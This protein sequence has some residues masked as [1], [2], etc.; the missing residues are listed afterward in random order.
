MNM[1]VS[2]IF[3]NVG[4]A[5]VIAMFLLIGSMIFLNVA[6]MH[7]RE[8]VVPDFTNMSVADAQVLASESD[9]RVEVIDSLYV[10]RMAKGHIY[11]QNPKSGSRV[12]KGR[13]ILL[14]INALSSK[15]VEV[16]D[17]VGFSMRQ[18]TAELQS[19]GLVLGKLIYRNDMATD[20]VLAQRYKGKAISPG[21]R[22]ET[23]SVVDLVVGLSSK[24]NYTMIPD[25]L[26]LKSLVA[27]DAVHSNSLNVRMV[28]D[29]SVKDYN[30]SLGAVVYAQ[31]PAANV[32]AYKGG[33]VT[34]YLTVDEEKYL[35]EKTGNGVESVS[36]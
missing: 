22:I 18:A 14:T 6:T 7:D 4:I 31:S 20:N 12:K 33:N 32:R 5:V 9:V 1:S 29:S 28:Y 16:P 25:V 27:T 23:G 15:T 26:G 19:R 13:R 35:K 36:E 17:L 34:M 21:T 10:K 2:K 8:L 24:D 3:I 30:D 11:K